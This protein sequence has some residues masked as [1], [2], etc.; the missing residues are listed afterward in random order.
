[1]DREH[2][3]GTW[4]LIDQIETLSD[5]TQILPR[6]E[7]PLGLLMYA[8]NGWMS[9]QLLRSERAA[10]ADLAEFQTAME[11]YL[12][13]FGTFTVDPARAIITHHIVGCSYPAYSGTDQV[14]RY[15]LTGDTLRL[16]AQSTHG[17][18]ILTW[19]RQR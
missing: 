6:G 13:Y 17:T 7:H 9:V 8:A 10:R 3:I 15:T 12:G 4:R 16:T 5:G 18:R 19:Q 11:E 1:M 14:R 2:L